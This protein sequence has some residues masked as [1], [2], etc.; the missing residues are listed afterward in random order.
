MIFIVEE[1]P[2][3][4]DSLRCLLEAEGL[5]I[6]VFASGVE[7]VRRAKTDELDCVILDMDVPGMS[8]FEVMA[9]LRRKEVKSP[10]IAVT[11]EPSPAAT[12]RAISEGAFQ[13]LE[14]P[15]DRGELLKTVRQALRR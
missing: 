3:V 5:E 12:I 15:F 1:D 11:A 14:K 7:F 4:R 8:G 9:W 6:A 13:V 2:A 10:I